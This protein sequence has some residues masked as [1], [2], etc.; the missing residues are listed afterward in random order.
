MLAVTMASVSRPAYASSSHPLPAAVGP[1]AAR[2]AAEGPSGIQVTG[3]ALADAATGN[4]LWSVG[5]NTERP[6]GS[7]VKVMTALV[8]IQAGDLNQEITVPE[9]VTAYLK[10]H[11]DPSTAGLHPG[12]QL[13]ALELLEALLLPSG[14]DAAYTLAMA[15]GPGLNAFIAK[16]NAEAGQLGLTSTYFSNFDGLPYPNENSTWST[17]ANLITLGRYAMSYPVFSQIV[18]QASYSLPAGDGH[19]AYTWQNTNPLIGVYQGAVGIKTGNT[20]A[21][22]NCL[23]FEAIQNGVALIGVTLGTP[24]NSIAD[25]GPVATSVLN[26]GFSQF[27]ATESSPDPV[28]PDPGQTNSGSAAVRSASALMAASSGAPVNRL[29]ASSTLGSRST[30]PT[31]QRN[32]PG[33]LSAHDTA[34]SISSCFSSG[35]YQVDRV[36]GRPAQGRSA[37]DLIVCT[38]TRRSRQVS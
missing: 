12:D 2:S 20:Q 25:T 16:M 13:T 15:Y 24:G 30:S 4:I 9:S 34:R 31:L 19:H 33:R 28:A 37:I 17:P 18:G 29:A 6:I 14:C 38:A 21:A 32:T 36:C 3:A 10:E 11:G 27:L 8:V 35:S 1:V 7:I 26:W 5:L 22:G 23:L